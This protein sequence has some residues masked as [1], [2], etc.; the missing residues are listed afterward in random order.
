MDL[1]IKQERIARGWTQEFVAQQ[2]GVKKPTV[3]MI[4]TGQRKP[5]YDV[6]VK[7]LDLFEYDDPRLL[8]APAQA[9]SK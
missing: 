1:V 5:S 4:E 3:S 6:L 9:G 8:F 2:V 7:L